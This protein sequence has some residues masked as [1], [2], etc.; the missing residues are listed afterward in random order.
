MSLLRALVPGAP[1]SVSSLAEA[2]QLL[3][4][5]IKPP[6]EAGVLGT[7]IFTWIS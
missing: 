5:A 7:R 3:G 2:S 1:G 4:A 6:E